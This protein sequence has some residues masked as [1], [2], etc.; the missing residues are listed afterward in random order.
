LLPGQDKQPKSEGSGI[1]LP[2]GYSS[3]RDKQEKTPPAETPTESQTATTPTEE[4][5][6]PATPPPA[7]TPPAAPSPAGQRRPARGQQPE[8]LFPPSGAQV[9]CPS[10]GTP[11]TVP[12]FSIIDLGA[13][14][15]LKGALLGG[16]INVASCPN[17]GVGGPLNVPLLVHEPSH[18]F[19]GVFAPPSQQK[20]QDH[21]RMQKAIGDLT[22]TL[23][24]KLP[25][26]ERKGYMLQPKQFMDWQGFV[27]Q[28][29]GFEGVTPEMLRRQRS[30]SELVQRLA[31]LAND[32][33]ALEMAL[34]RGKDLVDRDFFALLDRMLMMFSQQGQQQGAQAL[35]QLRNRLLETTDAG[36]EVKRIQDKIREI[37]GGLTRETT[38]EQLLDTVLNAWQGEDGEDVVN[39]LISALIPMLDY[40]FLMLV[41]ERLEATTDESTRTHLETLRET[42]LAIQE[43][44]TAAQQQMAQQM[45]AVLQEVLQA[46]DMKAKLREF[47]EILDESF[48]SLLAA[49]IQQAQRNGSTA[50]AKRLQQVYEAALSVLREQMPDEMRLLNELVSAP[51]KATVNQ[52]MRDNRDKLTPEF[53]SAMQSIEEELRA[54]GRK[55]VADRIKSLRGQIALM[56]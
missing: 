5:Q 38:R 2:K 24:R 16:Q 4:P 19:L 3:R 36:K 34:E 28:L 30:Q 48:L 13:N 1:E 46:P 35:A 31:T 8:L 49:N 40:Q 21:M 56:A 53:I 6:A 9:Q 43:Q 41:S 51:D 47:A 12:I 23:M 44:Q 27:E 25:T 39:G 18:Q 52:L 54:G 7:T 50:A 22:Q 15:E 37:A 33:K 20:G 26:E 10:C 11:Y 42:I 32:P 45:Q 55:E 29:W 17:C 14:P